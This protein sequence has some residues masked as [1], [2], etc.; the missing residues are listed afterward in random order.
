MDPTDLKVFEAVA[1]LG[2]MRGA[3]DELHTVQ[4]NVTA[5]IRALEAEVGIALF[6]RHSRGVTVTAAGR[7]L[8]PFVGKVAALLRDAAQATRDD[9]RP[10]G[11][12][13]IGALET[14]TALRLSPIL[15]GYARAYPDVD[16][17][18]RTGT[19]CE[20]IDRVLGHELEGAFVV[21]PVD[22]P[23]LDEESIFR[24]E[25]AIMTAPEV[26]SLDGALAAGAVKIVVL[27]IG[28][29]YR[30]RLEELLARRGVVGLRILEFGTL[31]AIFGCVA[32]GLGITLLPRALLGAVWQNG[33]VH[34]HPLPP[35]D[36]MVETVFV[37]RRDGYRSSAL[38]AFLDCARAAQRT[39]IAAE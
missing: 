21:G 9:G 28:C 34:V 1:R 22:H 29:S 27:R 24:E 14:T 26:T 4:S 12:L 6:D 7:R 13:V 38:A 32:A 11:P 36:A 25:L 30:H 8:L 33:R 2:S 35:A 15:S 16:L 3:A 31:E 17:I 39:A 5:R 19:S 23:A 37:R 10:K 18:L 20:L